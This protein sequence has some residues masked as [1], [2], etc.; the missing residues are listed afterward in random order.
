MIRRGSLVAGKFCLD[1]L[2]SWLQGYLSSDNSLN[3]ELVLCGFMYL[4]FIIQ[5]IQ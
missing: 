4:Y 5:I 3:H 1:L 2:T